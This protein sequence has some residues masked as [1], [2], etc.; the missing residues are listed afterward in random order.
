MPDERRTR[1]ASPPLSRE[2]RSEDPPPNRPRSSTARDALKAPPVTEASE[3]EAVMQAIAQSQKETQDAIAEQI[4]IDREAF[5]ER[6]RKELQSLLVKE[7]PRGQASLPPKKAGL[8]GSS[9]FAH[10]PA[11]LM[12][13]AALVGVIVQSCAKDAQRSDESSKKCEAIDQRVTA[14]VANQH[15]KNTALYNYL[16]ADR[17]FVGGVFQQGLDVKIVDP[18][19]AP[20]RSPLSFEPAPHAGSKAP[21]LQ[22]AEAFPVPPQMLE[23]PMPQMIE[24]R[25]DPTQPTR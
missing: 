15:S 24:I 1:Q 17:R 8:D 11:T 9:W 12:G 6:M 4:S 22:P 7:V 2:S 14:V 5:E 20:P 13:L 25:N 16:I 23:V 21:K 18:L 10:M 3:H 19:G